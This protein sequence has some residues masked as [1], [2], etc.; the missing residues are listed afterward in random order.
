MVP[1]PRIRSTSWF[2]ASGRYDRVLAN[3]RRFA[4]NIRRH[5]P[6][7]IFHSDWDSQDQVVLQYSRYMVGS[8]VPVITGYPPA[9]D[10]YTVPDADVVS[11][12]ASIWW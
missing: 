11:L 4:S 1:K 12:T 5:K 3:T 9:P 2:A 6:A 7:V 10:L 8:G